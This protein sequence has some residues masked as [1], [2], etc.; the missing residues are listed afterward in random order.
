MGSLLSICDDS[1]K[2]DTVEKKVI[3]T[4]SKKK[5]ILF[6]IEENPYHIETKV[7]KRPSYL[8]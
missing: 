8:H 6:K 2:I 7:K 5:R 1:D 4:H 3:K